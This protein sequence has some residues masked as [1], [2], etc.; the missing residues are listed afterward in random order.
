MKEELASSR[1]AEK[2]LRDSWKGDL[3]NIPL[4]KVV[5]Y[6]QRF[7][8]QFHRSLTQKIGV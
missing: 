3:D 4:G 7:A 6:M 5:E 8:E 2:L 1:E